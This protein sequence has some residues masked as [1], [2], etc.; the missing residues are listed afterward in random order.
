[1][2]GPRGNSADYLTKG[3]RPYVISQFGV[4]PDPADWAV[5]GWSSGG[6]CAIDLTVMH[7][8]LFT[9]FEDIG[10]DLGPNA[11][12]KQQTI[13][14]LYGGDAA[15]WDAY[16]PRTVMA[17]HGPYSGVAGYFDDSQEPP[18]DKSKDVPDRPRSA[19]RP[20]DTAGTL[21]TTNCGRRARCETCARPPWPSTSG[22]H[23]ACRSAN[24]RGSWRPAL[25]PMHCRGSH[26]GCTRQVLA[27]FRLNRDSRWDS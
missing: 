19:W 2:N 23:C 15:A 22:A 11:S 10:G 13:A 1:M 6:T 25:F 3:V 17:R 7:P 26:S 8:D 4:S 18:D 9:T 14:R 27:D 12:T 20:W 21:T 16:D 24:T 5:V